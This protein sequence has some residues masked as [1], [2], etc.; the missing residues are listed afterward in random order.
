MAIAK[1]IPETRKTTFQKSVAI[2]K[3]KNGIVKSYFLYSLLKY[4]LKDIQELAS[5]TSQSNLLLGSFRAF[6]IAYPGFELI[7]KF[8]ETIT[9][10]FDNIHI[11]VE[12]NKHLIELRNVI[13]SKMTKV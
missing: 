1:D 12:Q 3:P 2:L 9:P 7:C 13:F 10:I 8:E 11:K 5:G 4:N 6:K